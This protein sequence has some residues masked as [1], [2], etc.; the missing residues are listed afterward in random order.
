MAASK[1][2]RIIN[3]STIPSTARDASAP[4]K[5]VPAE[6]GLTRP[7]Q[8]AGGGAGNRAASHAGFTNVDAL[9]HLLGIIAAV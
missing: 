8:V 6:A 5:I 7:L 3:A 9:L 2:R 4:E 1:V